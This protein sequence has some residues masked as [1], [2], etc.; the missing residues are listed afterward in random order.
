MKDTVRIQALVQ[1]TAIAFALLFAID[2]VLTHWAVNTGLFTEQNPLMAPIAGFT[3]FP[4]FKIATGILGA[5]LVVWLASR[6]PRT[7]TIT[8]IGLIAF[9]GFYIWVFIANMI[10]VAITL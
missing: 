9:T 6:V 3:W 10:Q 1:L 4:I 7:A 2:G 8:L 5:Y